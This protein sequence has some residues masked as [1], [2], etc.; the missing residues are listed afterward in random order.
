MEEQIIFK[1]HKNINFKPKIFGIFEKKSFLVIM[2]SAFIILKI[3]ELLKINQMLKLEIII[4][5]L[6]PSLLISSNSHMY[7]NPIYILK[8]LI[9]FFF[10]KK[11]YL[12]EREYM[13]K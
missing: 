9:N 6:V 3:L 5:F 7:E 13:K 4:I 2:I 11:T 8:Y 12:Y 10:S 1:I